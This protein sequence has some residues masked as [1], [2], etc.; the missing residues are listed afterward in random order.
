MSAERKAP[1]RCAVYT[2]K[3][4]E[5]GL[6]QSFNSL[7]AQ[8][9]ACHAYILSQRQEGWR[10]IDAQ[11]DDGGYS[12]GTMERPGVRRL[13]E[14]IRAGKV[15]VIVVY[16]VDRLTRSLADFAKMIEILDA[17]KA[18]F[19]SITQQFNT[20][21]SMGRLTL[22]V[23]LSFAQFERE[24]AGERIRDK[25]AASKRKGMWMGGTVPLGYDIRDRKLIVNP[26]EAA[27][28][29]K[30][31]GLYLELGC[32]AKLKVQL[33][34]REIKSKIRVSK[35]GRKSGGFSYSRGALYELLK[36]RVYLGEITH[37]GNSY[38]GQHE[39]IISK[40]V[41]DKVQAQLS[42]NNDARRN[43]VKARHP[44][45]LAGLIHDEHGNRFTPSHSVKDGKRYRY[46]VS[47][48]A[49]QH[50]PNA[51][52]APVRIPAQEVEAAILSRLQSFLAKD[53]EVVDLLA[54]D[55]D[56]AS[57]TQT[58]IAAANRMA[59]TLDTA[60]ATE[61][62]RF[63]RLL[64]RGVVVREA[65]I[66]VKLG[67]EVT[68]VALAGGWLKAQDPATITRDSNAYEETLVLNIEGRVRRC[69]GEV[70]LI[71]EGDREHEPARPVPAMIKAVARAHE[72]YEQIVEGQSFGGRAI[73]ATTGLDERYISVIIRCAFLAPDIVEAILD[74][75]QPPNFT[76]AKITSRPSMNWAEQ[77][78]HLGFP[79]RM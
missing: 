66:E 70:R 52:K 1:V 58:L 4:S 68:R 41:W 23:L 33:G 30:I 43:G 9:E 10:A 69:G 50:L 48:A 19:V 5:E 35:A 24:V 46:Y 40:D 28:I 73:A 7:D 67:K 74:G 51:G 31:Y 26:A 18:S 25:I 55:S 12:G 76:L 22:N 34:K 13:F 42:T 15:D 64:V 20:T 61:V 71:L 16:K 77:R 59:K 57:T 65:S 72:W 63:V 6:E 8:R 39:G 38:P 29:R 47:Q 53:Q 14:D 62:C 2:R 11:Y 36:N 3:S 75:R 49:I 45:L 32:V 21:S 37:R 79:A 27:T 60:P 78:R 44:S 54:F 17:N 56:D